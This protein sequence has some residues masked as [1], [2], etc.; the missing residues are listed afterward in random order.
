MGNE[1][2]P[3]QLAEQNIANLGMDPLTDPPIP[4]RGMLYWN[5]TAWV[6]WGGGDMFG[7]V[8]S[9]YDYV[10][11]DY[12]GSNRMTSAV[13]KTGGSTGTTVATLT[14][15]YVGATTNIDTVTKV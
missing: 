7:L 9:A 1:F 4:Y 14:I 13:F 15:T 3:T 12:D 10:D 2:K 11:L 6:R 8:P 5:G